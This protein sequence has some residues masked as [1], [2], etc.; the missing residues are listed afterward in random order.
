LIITIY[1]D[2]LMMVRLNIEQIAQV[3]EALNR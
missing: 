1:V 3:K 2:D